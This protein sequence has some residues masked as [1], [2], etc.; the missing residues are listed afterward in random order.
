MFA[1][2][3]CGSGYNMENPFQK[4][5]F[6]MRFC[7]HLPPASSAQFIA[8]QMRAQ[9]T[10][11]MKDAKQHDNITMLVVI[12]KQKGNEYEKGR[13]IIIIFNFFCII[14]SSLYAD[15]FIPSR[16]AVKKLI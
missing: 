6:L 4:R 3:A 11:N 15:T 16:E 10:N 12:R 1:I 13:V 2:E 14:Y 8:D 7:R 5:V 9:L